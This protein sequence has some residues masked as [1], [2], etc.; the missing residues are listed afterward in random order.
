MQESAVPAASKGAARRHRVEGG[1][2]H[3]VKIRLTDAE[4]DAIAARAAEARVSVQRYLVGRALARTAPVQH[5]VAPS[6]LTAELAA[7]R[8]LTAN[9]A[10]NINQIARRLNSGGDPDAGMTATADAVLRTTRRIDAVLAW[11]DSPPRPNG[12]PPQRN[13][14]PPRRPAQAGHQN[15]DHRNVGLQRARPAPQRQRPPGRP[16]AD[17]HPERHPERRPDQHPDRRP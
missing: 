5:R 11:F 8:R 12:T 13:T 3:A 4:Y 10:S 1:R 14:A 17:R 6:A 9:L 16:A 7:V 2:P 15:A